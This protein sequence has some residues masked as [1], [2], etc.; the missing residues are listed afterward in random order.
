EALRTVQDEDKSYQIVKDIAD[1]LK[2]AYNTAE[3]VFARL[4]QTHAVKERLYQRAVTFFSTNEVVFTGLSASFTSMAGLSEA[5]NTME[6]MKTGMNQGLEALAKTGGAQLEAGLRSGYGS[7]LQ[8]SSVQALANAVVE[9]QA[10]T[11]TL[12]QEMRKEST[13][14][15]Q[16]IEAA[17]EDSK[18]RFVALISK[19]A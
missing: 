4:Q 6:A 13:Q 7:T 1:D 12:V 3:L 2:T 18:R 8:A 5:T 16:E 19:G 14:A 15:A 11:L 9:F 10:Q 17:A